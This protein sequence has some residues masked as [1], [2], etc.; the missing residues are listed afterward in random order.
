MTEAPTREELLVR[1]AELERECERLRGEAAVAARSDAA[2]S[3]DGDLLFQKIS[4]IGTVGI[5]FFDPA[6]DIRG[7]N[8]AFLRMG[9]YTR[10]DVAAGRLRWD[11]LT[12]PEWMPASRRAI[13]QLKTFGSTVPYEK[14]YYRKDGS[15]WWGLFAAKGL[16]E[17]LGVEFILDITQRKQAEAELREARK[18]AEV[19]QGEA[20]AANQVKADFL[21][22]MSHELRTPL[23]AVGGYVDLLE[24]GIHGPVTP[25]QLEALSR[26]R[27]NQRHLLMLINDILAYAKLEAGRIEFDLRLMGAYEMLVSVDPVVAP[28][29]DG[30]GIA[31]SLQSCDAGLRVNA[32]EERVRQILLNLVTNAIKFTPAGGWV[33]VN[34]DADAEWVYFRV[35]DNGPGISPEKLQ[36]IF[37]PFTQVGRRLN[38]PEDGVGLGL[39]ISRD[40]ARQM[41][42]DLEVESTFGAGS[43]FTLRLARAEDAPAEIR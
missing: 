1:V 22:S 18:L 13:D 39:A 41:G 30:K 5:I 9:G 25:A 20:E 28:M 4:E 36:V 3:S 15:R 16:S 14:E 10:E 7:A 29:A 17:D 23:N 19:A 27:F 2:F 34:C 38:R 8:D 43:T 42:G 31:Y 26:I 40:L 35:R 11:Q 12:P 32:D 6:G 33:L 37:D 24:M 21:A